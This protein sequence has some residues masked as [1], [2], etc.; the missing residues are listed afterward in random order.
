M[1]NG[2]QNEKRNRESFTYMSEEGINLLI[3][4]M[5][6]SNE[7]FDMSLN[8]RAFVDIVRALEFTYNNASGNGYRNSMSERSGDLLSTIAEH[9]GI[10]FI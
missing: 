7:R 2:E 10:E 9:F 5:K 3:R 6:D 4:R 8:Y 1:T